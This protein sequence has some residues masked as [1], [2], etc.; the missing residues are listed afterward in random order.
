LKGNFIE[1]TIDDFRELIVDT[2]RELTVDTDLHLLLDDKE[3]RLS[4][5]VEHSVYSQ[6]PKEAT[7]TSFASYFPVEEEATLS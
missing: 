5:K 7:I 6:S 3:L 4:S 1:L 2:L